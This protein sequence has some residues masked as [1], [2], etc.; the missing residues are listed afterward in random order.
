MLAQP[1]DTTC[2]PTCLQ[3]IYQ[4]HGKRISLDHVIREVPRLPR[5]GTLG[6]LLA[7]DA[8]RRGFAVTIYS[9]NLQIFDPTWEHLKTTEL[10]AKLT[11]QKKVRR[12]PKRKHAIQAF[13]DF[14]ELG[15][16]VKFV[17]MSGAL[18]RRYLNR[19]QP[20][21]AGLSS[22]YLYQSAREYGPDD[23]SD[24]LRGEPMGHFVVLRGYDRA[25]RQI[26]IVDPLQSN[27]HSTSRRYTVGIERVMSSILLGVLTYDANLIV[28][29]PDAEAGSHA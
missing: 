8:L 9:Y 2:G 11:A 29:K 7:I 28:I 25:S 10:I 4:Y 5:G 6:V 21:I 14:L 13:V 23:D 19:G 22:T 27:P 26:S 15:G 16:R 12:S 3:A 18:I 1:D 17:P 24:D 20:L